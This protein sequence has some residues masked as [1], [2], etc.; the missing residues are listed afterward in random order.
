MPIL[1]IAIKKKA[2]HLS[3][4]A[5]DVFSSIMPTCGNGELCGKLLHNATNRAHLGQLKRHC[6]KAKE[7]PL[8]GL[9]TMN[10]IEKDGVHIKTFPPLGDMVR[11]LFDQ[12]W[13]ITANH[14]H[15]SDCDRH[16]R[17]MQAVKCSGIFAWD[18]AFEPIKNCQKS[19]S[20]EAAWTVGAE[21]G[22]TAAV[23][24]APSTKTEDFSHAAQQLV[25]QPKFKPNTMCSD[26]WPHKNPFWG[27]FL[28]G[29]NGR[30]G[31][32]HCEQKTT[33]TMGKNHIDSHDAIADLLSATH[34]CHAPDCKNLLT[35]LKAGTLSS[36]RHK[37]ASQ[38]I[39]DL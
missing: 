17:E 12:A 33:C 34:S 37:C 27:L 39:A 29:I 25:K 15:L 31:L 6:S 10:H 36:N 8:A 7:K 9:T 32:F 20:A 3:G 18:H 28:P 38:E 35:A 16:A 22:E 4:S 21:T 11:D 30:L 24:S 5:A 19:V 2:S 14:W 13:C 1:S 23:A 26:T